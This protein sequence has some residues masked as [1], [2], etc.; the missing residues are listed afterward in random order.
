MVPPCPTAGPASRREP[1]HE[2]TRVVPLECPG[3]LHQIAPK[4]DEPKSR[5]ER[6]AARSL[7]AAKAIVP[8]TRPAAAA[9]RRRERGPPDLPNRAR[10]GCRSTRRARQ[11]RVVTTRRVS[12]CSRDPRTARRTR[13]ARSRTTRDAPRRPTPAAS[14]T[15]AARPAPPWWRSRPDRPR[16]G[17]VDGVDRRH[18]AR[19]TPCRP[20]RRCAWRGGIGPGARSAREPTTSRRRAAGAPKEPS[21]ST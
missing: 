4:N 14:A 20:P 7:T 9:R 15:P 11:A 8:M 19:E 1:T 21:H 2:A 12:D 10:A 13:R 5:N 18:R 6:R 3:D 17:S 16:E